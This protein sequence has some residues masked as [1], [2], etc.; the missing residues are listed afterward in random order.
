MSARILK[1]PAASDRL[2]IEVV[3]HNMLRDFTRGTK[4]RSI[5]KMYQLRVLIIEQILRERLQTLEQSERLRTFAT[6]RAA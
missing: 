4:M 2:P 1:F 6:R 3:Q 5:A